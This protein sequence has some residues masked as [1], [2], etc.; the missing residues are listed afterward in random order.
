M[1]SSSGLDIM[2]SK[3]R[4]HVVLLL[5]GAVSLII[6]ITALFSNCDVT[7]CNVL[8]LFLVFL[9][10]NATVIVSKFVSPRCGRLTVCAMGFGC[11]ALHVIVFVYRYYNCTW[12]FIACNNLASKIRPSISDKTAQELVAF[13]YIY[14][15][16]GVLAIYS[17]GIYSLLCKQHLT[18]VV[19]CLLTAHYNLF[20]VII[21]FYLYTNF[22]SENL[23]VLIGIL[24]LLSATEMLYRA[25]SRKAR[26]LVLQDS[27]NRQANWSKML[28][29]IHGFK[30]QITG[31]QSIISRGSLAAV[32]EPLDSKNNFVPITVLQAHADLDTLYRDC[33]V[34][35]FFFQDWVRTWFAS[36]K[37][38]DDFEFCNP[39]AYYKDV[40][41][42]RVPNCF[43]DVIRGPIKA[44]NRAISKVS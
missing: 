7:D 4:F 13:D 21:T 44:P 1:C 5:I 36:G 8:T 42:L 2:L 20:V 11:S 31:L 14:R 12:N 6:A 25:G 18:W 33:S 22:P 26:L 23:F 41:M 19:L 37:S 35:N 30:D 16:A 9:G 24:V 27:I 3:D 34:L 39:K 15:F 29:D 32:C 43:P 28:A 38:S 17:A 10:L 40:F